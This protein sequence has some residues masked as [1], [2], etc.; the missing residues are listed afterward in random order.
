MLSDEMV[1]KFR[2]LYRKRYGEDISKE[3]ALMQGTAL[4]R[5]MKVIYRPLPKGEKKHTQ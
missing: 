5:M 2:E 1:E 4:L 3:D